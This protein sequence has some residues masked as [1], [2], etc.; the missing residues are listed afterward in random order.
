MASPMS[1]EARPE[2]AARM[3]MKTRMTAVS[4]EFCKSCSS[5]LMTVDLSWLNEILVP[6]GSALANSAATIFTASTVSTRLAP[7]RFDTSTATA[8]LPSRRVID[9]AS[10]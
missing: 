9:S 2:S 5:C 1:S 10:L 7:V 4:T 3:T 8:G 6:S